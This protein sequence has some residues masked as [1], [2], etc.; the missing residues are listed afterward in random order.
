MLV[1]GILNPVSVLSAGIDKGK[2]L[3]GTW[4]ALTCEKCDYST[5][6]S[7]GKDWGMIHVVQTMICRD[8]SQLVDVVIGGGARTRRADRRCRLR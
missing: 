7:G 4:T 8:C 2:F 6:V 3:M 5:S 1:Q